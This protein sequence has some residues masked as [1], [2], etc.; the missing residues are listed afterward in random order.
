MWSLPSYI[1]LQLNSATTSNANITKVKLSHFLGCAS[2]CEAFRACFHLN[3][4]RGA[5]N[6]TSWKRR[7]E[8]DKGVG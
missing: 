5:A 6:G 2:G 1:S 4:K 3:G 8:K 7:V